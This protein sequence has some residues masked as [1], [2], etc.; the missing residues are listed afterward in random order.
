MTMTKQQLKD[1][2]QRIKEGKKNARLLREAEGTNK[3]QMNLWIETRG[4]KGLKEY[5]KQNGGSVS[6]IIRDLV[7]EFLLGES[8]D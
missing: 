2:G 6:E 8:L 1:R 3:V 4:L 7:D 5:V